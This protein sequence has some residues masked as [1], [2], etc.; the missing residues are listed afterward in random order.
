MGTAREQTATTYT[1]RHTMGNTG[2]HITC[3]RH[4]THHTQRPPVHYVGVGHKRFLPLTG[5]VIHTESCRCTA[6]TPG[7]KA[8]RTS[9]KT[10]GYV[11]RTAQGAQ[12]TGQGGERIQAAIPQCTIGCTEG[13]PGIRAPPQ[14]TILCGK[15]GQRTD[16]RCS[17]RWDVFCTL[18][19]YIHDGTGA[20]HL[21]QTLVSAEILDQPAFPCTYSFIYQDTGEVWRL[22]VP[23]VFST[24]MGVF[25]GGGSGLLIPSFQFKTHLLILR[26]FLHFC[27][28]CNLVRSL[29]GHSF[30]GHHGSSGIRIVVRDHG[31]LF[32]VS[33]AT[34]LRQFHFFSWTC[35]HRLAPSITT[36]KAPSS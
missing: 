36:W 28:K 15:Q 26:V 21:L 13:V 29:G 4:T 33:S 27:V 19:Q 32:S 5:Q 24:P 7:R 22:R 35:R 30:H 8:Q 31:L 34:L 1:Q 25:R 11:V 17:N 14:C 18:G 10:E 12:E 16:Q 3:G 2:I 6:H 20:Q 23:F 9:E